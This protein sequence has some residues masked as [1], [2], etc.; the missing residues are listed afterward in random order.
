MVSAGPTIEKIDPM[1]IL[2]NISSGRT[3][4]EIAREAEYRG[5]NVHLVLGNVYEDV[6]GIKNVYRCLTTKEM[7]FT[8]KGLW[9]KTDI[10]VSAAA[11]CDFR[12]VRYSR[13]KIKKDKRISLQFCENIDILGVLSRRKT[14]QKIIGFA[15][16]S[17]ALEKNAVAKMNSKNMDMVV[18]NYVNRH[19]L[20]P[21]AEKNKVFLIDRF[22]NRKTSP[23]LS[24][25]KLANWLWD[26]IEKRVLCEEE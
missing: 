10:F 18:A 24:K 19:G 22:N 6:S 21:Q 14:K 3:G 23:I 8:L 13:Q 20:G 9:E 25:D 15:A 26:E 12:P 17:G 5:A 4:C 1:R 11:I 2:T 16:E 7:L